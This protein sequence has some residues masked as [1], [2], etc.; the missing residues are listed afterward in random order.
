MT[1]NPVRVGLS[2]HLVDKETSQIEERP[3]SVKLPKWIW[4]LLQA[5]ADYC[6]NGNIHSAFAEIMSL[7]LQY[8]SEQVIVEETEVPQDPKNWN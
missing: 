7:G 4:G 8:L 5:R 3:V 2:I 1:N 6:H